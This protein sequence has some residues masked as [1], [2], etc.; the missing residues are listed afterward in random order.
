MCKKGATV[1]DEDENVQ[2]D[3]DDEESDQKQIKNFNKPRKPE[4]A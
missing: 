3:E 2:P 4:V 1:S